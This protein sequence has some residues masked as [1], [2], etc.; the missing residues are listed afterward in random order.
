MDRLQAMRAFV[1]V[2]DHNGFA[3]AA[4]M[5]GMSPPAVTRAVAA[6]EELYGTQLLRRTTRIV[7]LT[8]AGS[9]L[10]QDCRR[11][12]ELVDEAEASV[13]GARSEPR[14]RIVVTAPTMF[15][16]LYVAPL[17]AGFLDRFP[18]VDAQALFVD[19]IVDMIEEGVDVAVRIAELPDSSLTAVRIGAVRH[20]I[21]ATPAFLAAH[22]VP[23][24]PEDLMALQTIGFS[25]GGAGRPWHFAG[26]GRRRTLA[27]PSR[28]L[29]NTPDA[30][31]QAALAGH[32]IA[33]LFSYQ[34]AAELRSGA[35][36][37][38][39]EDY[40]PD[41]VPIHLVHGEG[42][43]ASARLRAFIDFAAERMRRDP[44]LHGA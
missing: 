20:V 31:L 30:A 18:E 44:R 14:G 6:L 17:L 35:L 25:L 23:Q 13:R 32:G 2:S 9:R 10:L 16:R 41:P 37:A 29:V 39:L 34:A 33:R 12:L 42:R 4:R 28:L 38:V 21:C 8:D 7:R 26:S 19:R 22:G 27:P 11:I 24:V 15:G 1:A 43:R 36:Q 3:P 5:L 40:A